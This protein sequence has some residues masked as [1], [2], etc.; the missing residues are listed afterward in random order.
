MPTITPILKGSPNS[1]SEECLHTSASGAV[2]RQHREKTCLT[3]VLV[4]FVVK[5]VA[6]FYIRVLRL[7]PEGYHSIIP[8]DT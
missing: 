5:Y 7:Y 2:T 3:L 8:A 1:G 6:Q 4:G